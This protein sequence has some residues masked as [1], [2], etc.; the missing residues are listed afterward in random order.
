MRDLIEIAW[1]SRRPK[2]R[3]LPFFADLS[4]CAS[5]QVWGS[6]V[7]TLATS[8]RI[9]DFALQRLLDHNEILVL[10]GYAPSMVRIPPRVSQSNLAHAIGNGMFLPS[11]A[12][13]L[14]SVFLMDTA[15]WWRQ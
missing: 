6:Q 4:Q 1:A 12:K 13:Y 9:F 15:P 7:S 5:R 10:Q 14:V 3:V 11:L 2:R 8:A